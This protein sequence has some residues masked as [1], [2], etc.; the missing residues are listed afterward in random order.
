M[1]AKN[2][3]RSGLLFALFFYLLNIANATV[4]SGTI[5]HQ[6]TLTVGN[7]YNVGMSGGPYFSGINLSPIDNITIFFLQ[8]STV[9]S[10]I[11]GHYATNY[12]VWT[13]TVPTMPTGLYTIYVLNS[14]T[15]YQTNDYVNL[16]IVGTDPTPSLTFTTPT[17]ASVNVGSTL[18]NVVTSTIPPPTGGAITYTSDTPSVATVDINTG[19]VTG[20]SVGSAIIT[21]TQSAASGVNTS[22]TQT[23]T[24]T[25]GKGTPTIT[26]GPTASSITYGQTLASSS[27]TGG[28]A[29]IAGTFAFTN[30]GV[31]PA[32]GTS[33]QSVTFTPTNAANYN[34]VTTNVSVNVGKAPAGISIVNTT[35]TYTGKPISVTTSLSPSTLSAAVVYYPGF[36]A[37]TEAGTYYVLVNVVDNTY[38]GSQSS[39]LTILPATQTVSIA[40]PA[41]LSIGVPASLSATSTSNGPITYSVVSGNAI[42]SGSTLTAL[43]GNPVTIKATQSG[44]NDYQAASSTITLTASPIKPA[45][46]V[47]PVSTVTV[48][49]GSST[50]LSVT[51]TGT[52]PTY[53]W[54][55]GSTAIAGATSATYTITSA[56][57]VSAGSYTCV[58]TNTLGS[59]TSTPEVVSV[60]ITP[61]I[62]SN[63]VSQLV[64][65]GSSATFTVNASG[66]SPT[67][68]WNLNG[69]PIAGAT[70]ASYT[71]TASSSTT[72]NY[73]CTITNA[74]GSVTT[75][76]A[77]LTLNTTHLANLSSR[78]IVGTSNL[79]VGFVSTGSVSKS[80]LLRGDGPSL[81]NYGVTGVLANPVLTLYNSSGTSLASNSAWGGASSLSSI[82]TQVGAFPL[83]A[84]SNDAVLNQSL[85]SGTYSAIVSG[86]NSSTGAAMVEIYD[87]DPTGA[88]SRLVN[89]SARGMVGTGSSIMTGGFVITGNSTETVL[90]RAVGP[91]LSTY[92]VTGV[93]AQPTLTVYNASGTSVAS[94]TVWGGGSTLSSAMT[95]VGAF[96]LPTTSADSAVLV[97]LPAGAYTVQ[98]SGV[99]GTTG[100]ALV[101]I[102]EVSSP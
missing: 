90:I 31:A 61:T 83:T 89:I 26:S 66:T 8:G 10:S 15:G 29:S 13:F 67:Y 39:V 51:A 94:N 74:A 47:Q 72:G 49:Q 92:G 23:Y 102:Y 22:A 99:N 58:V 52:A 87:A 35:Q 16:S 33:T 64:R 20:V 9:V 81:A 14:T 42:L 36:N 73:T 79:T 60:I 100:N 98:V 53:Q 48:N 27:L 5:N 95:Q 18:T 82:F 69:T 76:A 1:F 25:V 96:A 2:Y 4:V 86:A 21:A 54:Y 24:V 41:T 84:A 56:S 85:S 71:V 45:I 59:V 62:T 78:A 3:L 28:S 19:V 57:S 93:L 75:P 101:E 46:S 91:T 63:P 37:P 38:Y 30:A 77:T 43:D 68:Q 65:S 6:P 17:T 11:S 7:T 44:T 34:S 32:L 88:T 50:T 80:I 40:T 55:L 97:T 12:N 70:S